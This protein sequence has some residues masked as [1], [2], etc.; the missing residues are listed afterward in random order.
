MWASQRHLVSKCGKD[1]AELNEYLVWFAVVFLCLFAASSYPVNSAGTH[2]S[3]GWGEIDPLSLFR[4]WLWGDEYSFLSLVATETVDWVVSFEIL[5][6]SLC[7]W[8]PLPLCC[9]SWM[10]P[11]YPVSLACGSLLLFLSQVT[12]VIKFCSKGKWLAADAA[13]PIPSSSRHCCDQWYQQTSASVLQRLL[14]M[15]TSNLN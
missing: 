6:A 2:K 15:G 7:N 10:P 12:R 4:Y 1:S 13:S 8:S 3:R 11:H 14:W 9:D 5:S